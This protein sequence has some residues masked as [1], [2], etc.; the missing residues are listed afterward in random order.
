MDAA[1]SAI[2]EG[3]VAAVKVSRLTKKLGVSRGSFYW[4]FESQDE[5]VEKSLLRWEAVSTT[6]VL[7]KLRTS[8]DPKVRLRRLLKAAYADVDNGVLFSA[9]A[10]SS[11]DPRVRRTLR[12]IT[13]TRMAFVRECYTLMGC[14]ET[15]AEHR[16]LLTYSAYTGLYDIVRALPARGPKALAGKRLRAYLDH[17][18]SELVDAV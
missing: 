1:L 17:L 9:L 7:A 8:D 5:L 4:H 12:R 2:A 15:D 16:A 11:Q 18:V 10:A 14:D 3:G 6:E 13:T